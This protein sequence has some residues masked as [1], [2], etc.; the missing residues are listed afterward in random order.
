MT[1][2]YHSVNITVTS[3]YHESTLTLSQ[4]CVSNRTIYRIKFGLFFRK[5]IEKIDKDLHPMETVVLV[6]VEL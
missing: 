3:H 4:R 1:A 6:T 5:I 2:K